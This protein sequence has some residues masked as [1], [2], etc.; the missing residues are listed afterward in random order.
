MAKLVGKRYA[1]A[2]Y[3]VAVESDKLQEYKQ[4]IKAV[5]G[6]FSENPELYNIFTH[7]RV[8]KDEKKNMMD[9]LFKG[10]ISQEVLNLFYIIIDKGRENDLEDISEAYV[11]L[12]NE[13]LGIVE[14]KAYTAVA[15]SP[16]EIARLQE[17]LSSKFNKKV[18]LSN[19]IDETLLGGV[20]VKLGDKVMDGTVKGRLSEIQRELN[21]IRLT[22][23]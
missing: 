3:E 18:N 10:K 4:E 21:N 2:L 5:T 20:L 7:P 12:S 1:E 8:T 23:E 11:E 9:E 17:K 13:K 16:E 15:M 14:A 19:H 6:I 22:A